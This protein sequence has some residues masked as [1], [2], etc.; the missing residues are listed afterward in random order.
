MIFYHPSLNVKHIFR[1]C[2]TALR[3]RGQNCPQSRTTAVAVPSAWH[4]LPLKGPIHTLSLPSNLSADV[5]PLRLLWRIYLIMQT[6]HLLTTCVPYPPLL[7]NFHDHL[8]YQKMYLFLCLYFF[9]SLKCKLLERA[10]LFPVT[11]LALRAVPHIL[12]KKIKIHMQ[13]STVK[14]LALTSVLCASSSLPQIK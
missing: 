2:Q 9:F 6:L 13:W 11:F 7:F 5:T 10:V 3:E 14:S 12:F 4:T 1:Y 8:M